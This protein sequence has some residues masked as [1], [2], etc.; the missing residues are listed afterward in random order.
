MDELE[1]SGAFESAVSD[2]SDLDRELD[3]LR[4]E[5]AVEAELET[6]KSE[7]GSG[8]E[9]KA[10]SDDVAVNVDADEETA[11]AETETDVDADIE[12]EIDDLKKDDE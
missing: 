3:E 6:L 5:G 2:E 9:S 8:A 4:Q 7:T 10:D 11:E 12:A 1:E